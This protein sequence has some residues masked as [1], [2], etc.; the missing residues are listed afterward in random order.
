MYTSLS[1]TAGSTNSG[2]DME[3]K[4][5]SPRVKSLLKVGVDQY[6]AVNLEKNLG[7]LLFKSH[8]VRKISLPLMMLYTANADGIM[9][10]LMTA[11]LRRELSAT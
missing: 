6:S 3:A 2:A 11:F 8:A 4:V 7:V 9:F 5:I 10:S 1:M